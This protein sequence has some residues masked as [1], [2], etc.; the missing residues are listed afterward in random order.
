MEL[1]RS[2]TGVGRVVLQRS[3]SGATAEQERNS[4]VAPQKLRCNSSAEFGRSELR[5]NSAVTPHFSEVELQ[6]SYSGTPGSGFPVTFTSPAASAAT[7]RQAQ[8]S[9]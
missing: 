5:C 9:P 4:A 3:C 7:R 6:R 8:A 1:Q 2:Y